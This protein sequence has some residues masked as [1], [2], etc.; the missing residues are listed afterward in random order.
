MGHVI[1]SAG[2]STDPGKIEAVAKWRCPSE[3]SELRSFLG[4][5]SYYRQFVEGFAKL[6]AP[7]HKLLAE[8]AGTKSRKGTGRDFAAA[9][10]EACE[11]SFEGLK[12]KLTSTPVLAY[13]N[14]ALPFIL[15]IDASHSGLGA[16][17]SQEQEGK[18]RP[19]AYASHGLRPPER[20]MINYSSMK[21]QFLA[22]KRAVTKKFREYPLGHKS[23]IYT[24][25]NPLESPWLC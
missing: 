4:F 13:A 14:F 5:A 9:W 19:I 24:D 12:T 8:L 23:I 11:Q 22:L 16:V 1:F 6:A 3:V 10:T 25:N 20:N 7:L 18:V 2:V 17:L 21:L 15:E